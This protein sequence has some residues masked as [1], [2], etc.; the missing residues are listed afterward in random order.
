MIP[1]DA[2]PQLHSQEPI[3]VLFPVC[4]LSRCYHIQLHENVGVSLQVFVPQYCIIC[5]TNP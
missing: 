4:H 1:I 5:Q 3:A 2:T